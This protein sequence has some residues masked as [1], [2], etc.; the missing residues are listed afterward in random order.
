LLTSTLKVCRLNHWACYVGGN[1][2]DD[3]QD[4]GS[5]AQHAAYK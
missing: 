5:W 4:Q 2:R 1:C 3:A